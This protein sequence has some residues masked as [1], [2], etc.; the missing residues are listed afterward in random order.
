[1]IQITKLNHKYRNKKERALK[2][3]D[4]SIKKGENIVL[5]GQ[6]GSGKSTLIKCINKLIKPSSGSILINNEDILKLNSKEIKKV[7]KRIAVIFQEFNL[8][9]KETVLNN[10]LNG[11]LGHIGTIN[12]FLGRFDK[13]H[14]EIATTNLEKVGLLNLRNEKVCNLSGG[15]KQRV[16][17]ARALAQEPEIILADEPV[18]NLDPKLMQ[19]IISLLYNLC[20]EKE[21]TLISSL[22]FIDLVK[23][24]SS[25]V[26]GI[27]EGEI[28]FDGTAESITEWE[29]VKIYGKSD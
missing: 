5:L 14:K 10:V 27:K 2:E 1:M 8:L 28:V 4:L 3:I 20:K 11:R 13:K 26:I 15:Q 22:H 17:I 29:M 18:S 6:S 7:R 9:E 25:R 19:E 23:K 12:T 16:A 24:N 21:I